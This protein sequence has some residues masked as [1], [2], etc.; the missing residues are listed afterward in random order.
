MCVCAVSKRDQFYTRYLFFFISVPREFLI[1]QWSQ[2]KLSIHFLKNNFSDF[3]PFRG[4][5]HMLLGVGVGLGV[6]LMVTCVVP[7]RPLIHASEG[8]P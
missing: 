3:P 6:H 2:R 5:D 4:S 8:K 7:N 1:L